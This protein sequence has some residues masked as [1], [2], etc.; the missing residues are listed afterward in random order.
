MAS[1]GMTDNIYLFAQVNIYELL[2]R[3]KDGISCSEIFSISS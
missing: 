1:K 2:W 3:Q